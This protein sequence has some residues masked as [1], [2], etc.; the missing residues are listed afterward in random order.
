MPH[1][2]AFARQNNAKIVFSS[3]LPGGSGVSGVNADYTSQV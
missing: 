2:L 1:E 3:D